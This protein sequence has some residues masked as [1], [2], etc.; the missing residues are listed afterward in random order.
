MDINTKGIDPNLLKLIPEYK[1]DLEKDQLELALKVLK[2]FSEIR[3]STIAGLQSNIR[4]Q[5]LSKDRRILIWILYYKYNIPSKI[6]QIILGCSRSTPSN[7]RSTVNRSNE[8]IKALKIYKELN[9]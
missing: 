1:E 4:N 7:A 9:I 3:S 2:K 6:I 8:N 5:E